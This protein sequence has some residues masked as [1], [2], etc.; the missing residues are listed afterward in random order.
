MIFG[1]EPG[2]LA[3]GRVGT[4]RFSAVLEVV[5]CVYGSS[6]LVLETVMWYAAIPSSPGLRFPGLLL[7]NL[8]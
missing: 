7:R 8:N 6:M 5:M 2:R 1:T 3:A 4:R